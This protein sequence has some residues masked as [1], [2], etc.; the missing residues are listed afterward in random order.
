[1]VETSRRVFLEERVPGGGGRDEGE[2][3]SGGALSQHEIE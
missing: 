3:A 2:R 1:M